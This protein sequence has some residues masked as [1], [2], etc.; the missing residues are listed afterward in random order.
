MINNTGDLTIITSGTG[1]GLSRTLSKLT[2]QKTQEA[3]RSWDNRLKK[4]EQRPRGKFF[5]SHKATVL[6]SCKTATAE[7]PIEY[8]LGDHS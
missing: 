1:S 8:Y 3:F 5:K 4:N 7:D 6:C 2:I